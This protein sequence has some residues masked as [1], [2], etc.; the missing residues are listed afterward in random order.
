MPSLLKFDVSVTETWLNADIDSTL[1]TPKGFQDFRTDRTCKI[2]TRG[3]G[4]AI[5]IIHGWCSSQKHPFA[6]AEDNVKATAVTSRTK[7]SS[8]IKCSIYIPLSTRTLQL[9]PF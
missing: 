7:L 4:T 2:N 1:I 9:P 6:Y 8:I 3:G 5:C